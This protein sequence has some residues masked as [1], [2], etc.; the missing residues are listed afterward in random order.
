MDI[1][2]SNITNTSVLLQNYVLWNY[3]S[4]F[5]FPLNNISKCW[6]VG[7]SSPIQHHHLWRSHHPSASSSSLEV[8]IIHIYHHHHHHHYRRHSLLEVINDP[9]SSSSSSSTG[10]TICSHDLSI[11]LE[12]DNINTSSRFIES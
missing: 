12:Y 6:P 7:R 11:N 3:C 4:N 8:I 5:Q 10:P 2:M 9:L 1:L